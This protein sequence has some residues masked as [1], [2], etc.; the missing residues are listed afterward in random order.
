MY[1]NALVIEIQLDTNMVYEHLDFYATLVIFQLVPH[2][3]DLYNQV[4]NSVN[5]WQ[6]SK[7]I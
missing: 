1:S 4:H 6:K 7:V 2:A 5:K 3:W